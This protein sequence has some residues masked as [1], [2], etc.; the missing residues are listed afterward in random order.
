[1]PTSAIVIGQVIWKIKSLTIVET[2]SQISQQQ[3]KL[4]LS[5]EN[6]IKFAYRNNFSF[7]VTYCLLNWKMFFPIQSAVSSL[8][9]Y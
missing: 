8:P 1:M 9:E 7:K 3:A 4:F 6:F 5:G 2:S